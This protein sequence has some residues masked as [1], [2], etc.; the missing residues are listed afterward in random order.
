MLVLVWHMGFDERCSRQA[1]LGSILIFSG[2]QVAFKKLPGQQETD[3]SLS[4]PLLQI[5]GSQGLG[6][7]KLCVSR[8]FKKL[9]REV[10]VLYLSGPTA[11]PAGVEGATA[12]STG[13][14][15]F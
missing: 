2:L 3:I 7:G 8:T 11:R 10:S 1:E 6:F 13:R 5:S 9:P 15:A 12:D 4:R 14:L